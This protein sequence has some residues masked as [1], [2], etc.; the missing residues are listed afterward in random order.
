MGDVE[1]TGPGPDTPAR[2]DADPLLRADRAPAPRTLV[3]VLR[4]TAD[5]HPDS[6][7]I[8]NGREVLTYDELLTSAGDVATALR[9][10]GVGRGDRVGVRIPSGTTDLYVAI[11]GILLAGAAYVPVDHDDPDERARLV[12]NEAGVAAVVTADL[13]ILSTEDAAPPAPE[14]DPDLGD[15]AWIIFTSGSTGTPKGVAVSH[16]SAAAFVDAE[17][18]MF[19]QDKPIQPGDR[20]MAGL[21]VA[22]DASCEEMWL[23]W[24]HGAC[25]IPAPRSLVKSGMDLGPWLRA[26]GITVVSTVP[27]L[28][29]L[30]PAQALDDVRLLI[31]GGEAC[32]PEIGARLATPAR[33]VWNTYGPTEATV[34]ACGA[35]L[36]GE[37]PVRIGLPLDGWDLAVV[38]SAGHRVT[39]GE[40]GELII[41]GVGLA[42][43]LDPVKDASVYAAMPTL[44]W[45]RAYRSGDIVRFDGEGLVFNGRADDQ[46]KVGGRRIELGEVDS[47]LLAL[48]AVSGAAAAVRRSEAGNSL[49]VGYVTTEPAFDAKSAVEQLRRTMPAALVPRL[50]VVDTLPTRTSGKIDRDALPWP[51]PSRP[52]GTAS[53]QA[54]PEVTG[55]AAWVAGHWTA[56]LGG[57]P[58]GPDDDFF[59]LGGGSLT[60][61][62]LVSRLRER[63]P[64]VTVA[65]VYD[66]P[67]LADLAAALDD[68]ATPT[69]RQNAAVLPVPL[70]TQ[71]AQVLASVAFRSLGALRWLTWVGA[72]AVVGR[73]AFGLDWLPDVGWGWVLLGWLLL[74]SPP[75]RIT[76][77]ALAARLALVGVRP[78][79]HPRGGRVHLRLWLAERL[80]DE[81][82]ATS[83]SSAPLVKVYARLLGCT[84][85]RHVDLH[86]VPPVT[87][88]L[89][90]GDGCSVEPEV[91][92]A[93][94]WLD[95]GHLHIG[96]VRVG[97]DARVGSRSTLLPGA[98]VGA[99]AEVAAG[100][101]VFGPV[102]AGEAWSG[103]PAIFSGRA[104]G[105]WGDDR[106]PNRPAWLAAY[107]AS[108]IVLSWLPILAV[109]A[110]LAVAAPALADTD[111]I[112][113]AVTTAL[114]WLPLSTVVGFVVLG[115]L[116]LVAVR[117][118]SL[119]LEVG[120]HPVHGRQA[121]QAW[122]MLRVL[123][124]A[125][126]W[127]FP[128]YSSGLTPP[129]LRAL[130]ADIGSDVEA[131]T[132][133]MIPPFV[134][135][136]SGAFLADD[137]LVGGYELGG[138]W[139]RVEHV[140]VG[141][142]AFVGNSGMAA[143][144]R[145]VPKKALVAVLSAAPQR[146]TAKAGTS[147][148]GSPP[149]PLRRERD[150]SD[151]ARTHAPARR[152]RV[153]RALVELGRIVPVWLHVLLVVLVVATL[154]ALLDRGAWWAV[155]LGGPVLL[156][157]GLLAGIVTVVA[158]W[159][160]VGR[161]SP[162]EHPLWSSFVWRNELADTF[163]EVVAAP[164]FAR[165]ATGTSVLNLWLR[166]MGSRIGRGVWCETYWLPEADLI[167]LRAGA[168][169][170]RG[171]VVQTHLFH[172]R[173]L[174]MDRVTI[175]DGGTLGPNSVIL[176]AAR[177]G[178]HATVGPVSLVMRGESVPDKTR[179]IGNPV[180][181]WTEDE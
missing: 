106:P 105:P 170:G 21:S 157:A 136:G 129:W 26:N 17:A 176:P 158:K 165:A 137:T 59:D 134:R 44:G 11:V 173:I 159:L 139:L 144:G 22:F 5:D 45:D 34:V 78:G 75:G 1:S 38:V 24:R 23:A 61:A 163:V 54:P 126:T 102:P 135:V 148:L 177:I 70:A 72:G 175:A 83:L 8:D 107:T 114:L 113:D 96:S 58:S 179:W 67:G 180:G 112:P 131:S 168:T 86:S 81:L 13:V 73:A 143:P 164:W 162:S 80:V 174:S 42:R 69:G 128:I 141:K 171:C 57:A 88:L 37:P 65:D 130:G 50:V 115:A 28:V 146:G 16:R 36:T 133:L 6:P 154:A 160:L 9:D 25:L 138:G 140:R 66:H 56:I 89:T 119:G 101:A 150:D 152:L 43:Y 18:R 109:L 64:E 145:R 7:A 85:G 14:E 27:T 3:D 127:L 63:F 172:D 125:R 97:A 181:P 41:G 12:F 32:P 104:R 68:M 79:T 62:Q 82:G 33:E 84:V 15:D 52:G 2:E 53:D 95:G 142:G 147:W 116:V 94:H 92:L 93:G 90:L 77:G 122:S 151:A 55:T 110:G 39:A 123:D 48:P 153:G 31:L 19:L 47:A 103:A 60:A 49:L 87:G 118:L 132:V 149:R 35:R 30:W 40:P 121:W 117:L 167:D 91:D 100:S 74:I 51:P 98:D 4:S 120:H 108:A 29:T 161:M 76:L 178:R 46:V 155:L 166:A 169:V 124:E 71:V 156:V 10:E 111:G 20:V 99:G